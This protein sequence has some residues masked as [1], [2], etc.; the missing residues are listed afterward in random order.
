MAQNWR[1]IEYKFIL[2]GDSSVGKSSIFKRL[3]GNS[4]S[5]NQISTLGTE[6]A[7]INFDDLE[8]DKNTRQNFKI[9]LF[10]T[11]GQ[12][13][14]RA[15]T[16]S[17]FRDSQGIV[18]IYS[19]V[20]EESFKHIEAWLDSI[21]DSLSDWKRSGYIVMLL[22]NKLDIA[23][24]NKEQR[25]ILKEEAEKICS[26]QGIY[27][28]GEC[29]AKTFDENKFKEIF[30]KFMKQIYLKLGNDVKNINNNKSQISRKIEV[31]KKS[32]KGCC[33]SYA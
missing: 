5:K 32:Q 15:I 4:F 17:Y 14:Y 2:L 20:D 12:E 1:P 9:V 16:K 18:L 21:K 22:G 10:D 25:M 7:I 27:W 26:E 33:S 29:S 24:E 3:L 6:K 23:E 30:E 13:R 19:I 28:G 8:I 11:A 31:Y